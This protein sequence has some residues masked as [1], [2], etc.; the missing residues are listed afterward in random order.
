MMSEAKK[1]LDANHRRI[2]RQLGVPTDDD[3]EPDVYGSD[4]DL[5]QISSV[6]YGKAI[7]ASGRQW[8]D[9]MMQRDALLAACEAAEEAIDNYIIKDRVITDVAC[10]ELLNQ[11]GAAIELARGTTDAK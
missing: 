11:L 1:L 6:H 9:A 2:C 7:I 3:G 10:V 8:A 5:V 4:V